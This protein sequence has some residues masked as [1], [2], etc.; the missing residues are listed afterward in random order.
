MAAASSLFDIF[1]N[2]AGPKPITVATSSVEPE[3]PKAKKAK[4][5]VKKARHDKTAK[6]VVRTPTPVPALVERVET[7]HCPGYGMLRVERDKIE[8]S[9]V[10]LTRR[11]ET[12]A[13]QGKPAPTIC[14]ML[15]DRLIEF[16]A[17]ISAQFNTRFGKYLQETKK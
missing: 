11:N 4:P 2:G 16:Y 17:D 9:R 7:R 5:K 12:R 8:R 1:T 13:A 3:A 14:S 6:E 10:A 15:N